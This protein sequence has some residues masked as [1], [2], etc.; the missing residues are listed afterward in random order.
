[1]QFWPDGLLM[2][3]SPD[4]PWFSMIFDGFWR[5][6][7]IFALDDIQFLYSWKPLNY[8]SYGDIF[9]QSPRFCHGSISGTLLVILVESLFNFGPFLTKL[10]FSR[11]GP[12]CD[13]FITHVLWSMCSI[14]TNLRLIEMKFG[15]TLR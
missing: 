3:V 9:F 12:I 4:F 14:S 13:I 6:F 7:F 1:M 2:D 5:V 15:Q 11:F 10:A 8:I